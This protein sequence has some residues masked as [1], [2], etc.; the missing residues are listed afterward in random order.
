M[1][2]L[3]PSSG[4]LSKIDTA[5]SPTDRRIVHPDRFESPKD[6]FRRR[7]SSV[8]SGPPDQIDRFTSEKSINGSR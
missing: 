7:E 5:G 6:R 3:Q 2:K 4:S 1:I 8:P